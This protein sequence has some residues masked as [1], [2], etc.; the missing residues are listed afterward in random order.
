MLWVGYRTCRT[1][2]VPASDEWLAPEEMEVLG[3]LKIQK[4]RSDFRLGRFAAKRALT[5][6]WSRTGHAA[7]PSFTIVAA[8]DGAPE[9]RFE[10]GKAAPFSLSISHS[11]AHA[12]CA[13]AATDQGSLRLG[14]DLELIEP[15]SEELV[16]QFFTPS[17]QEG[18]LSLSAD[19]APLVATLVWSAKESALK[20]L[21]SGLRADTRSVEIEWLHGESA[22]D[23]QPLAASSASGPKLIGFWRTLSVVEPGQPLRTW[24]LTLLSEPACS[25]PELLSD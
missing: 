5:S 13:V 25:T 20:A 9:A 1:V 16:R 24:V 22:S 3:R 11:H 18:V 23:W 4:R 15:R 19:D 12:A 17:E 2:E 14:C 10:D 7:R 21:R 6:A 8:A